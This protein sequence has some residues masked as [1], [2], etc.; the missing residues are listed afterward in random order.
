MSEIEEEILIDNGIINSVNLTI[1]PYLEYLLEPP[2]L[3]EGKKDDGYKLSYRITNPHLDMYY[4]DYVDENLVLQLQQQGLSD[5]EI[6]ELE[7]KKRF[8][9]I[10]TH[11]DN[12]QL[13]ILLDETFYEQSVVNVPTS[14]EFVNKLLSD[15]ILVINKK[16]IKEHN[17]CCGI[18]QSPFKESEKAVMLPCKNSDNHE[19][20]HYF[21]IG[22][23]PDNCLGIKPWLDIS[24]TCP[25]C[26]FS[27]PNTEILEEEVFELEI[28]EQQ[29]ENNI[30]SFSMDQDEIIDC[31]TVFSNMFIS[32]RCRA[33]PPE[34][35]LNPRCIENRAQIEIDKVNQEMTDKA[36]QISIE[37]SILNTDNN[38]LLEDQQK[39][40]KDID[41]VASEDALLELALSKSLENI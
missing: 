34:R 20:P 18:C 23:N 16:F 30:D 7:I 13:N 40:F 35:C 26:R 12:N 15:D 17:P 31:S 19:N 36:M 11:Y 37:H 14:K 27:F 39:I 6:C 28:D 8:D 10:N 29:G 24:S 21:H 4:D 22:D 9:Y 38:C 25:V 32:D 1:Y 5:E 2:R 3:G 33:N 41:L